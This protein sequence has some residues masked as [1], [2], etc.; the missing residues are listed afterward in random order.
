MSTAQ[1]GL[2]QFSFY[3]H[4]C[5]VADY[6]R[7][8]WPDLLVTGYGRM[9]LFHNESDGPGRPEVLSRYR[10]CRPARSSGGAP[11][12]PGPTSMAMA[13]PTSTSATT[14]IGRGRRTGFA[15]DNFAI[16]ED[17]CPPGTFQGVGP[18]CTGTTGTAPSPT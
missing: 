2:D 6:D 1:V 10:G 5:A 16:R 4:G 8:G 12:P 18:R 14:S 11:V 7:D 17:V 15:G 9:A 13:I 3:A